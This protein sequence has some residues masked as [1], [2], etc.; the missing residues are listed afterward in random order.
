MTVL[1][2]RHAL[3][4]MIARVVV[5]SAGLAGVFLIGAT[6]ALAQVEIEGAIIDDSTGEPISGATVE[7]LDGDERF[8]QRTISD[9]RG[10]FVF[11]M[12]RHRP[13]SIEVRR[14]G[15][16]TV[17]T[18]PL[19][20]R[21]DEQLGVEIRMSTEAVLL[22]PLE[23]V[24]RSTP[25]YDES[26]L[27]R[28]RFRAEAGVAGHFISREEIR[29]RNASHLSQLLEVVPGVRLTTSGRGSGGRRVQM[30][31]ALPGPGGGG[32][33][34]QIFLDGTLANRDGNTVIDD[35]VSPNDVEGI[36]IYRGMS[37]V[38]PEFLNPNAR[39]G[40]IGIWTRR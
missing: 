8:L 19:S 25:G 7:L 14:I 39:C 1:H 36:E 16:R 33:P 6:S 35:L 13:V 10:I 21:R 29:R 5:I 34:V 40:V 11:R 27:S 18:P 32:C 22:A 23:V 17:L 30:A 31:R 12:T 26:V 15:Y 38:P 2:A 4:A 3:D 24:V 20:T 37:S 28:F 9:E